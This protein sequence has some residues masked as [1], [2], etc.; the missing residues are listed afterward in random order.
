MQNSS[1]LNVKGVLTLVK[2]ILIAG[3]IVTNVVL[4]FPASKQRK[5]RSEL[6]LNKIVHLFKITGRDVTNLVSVVY[7]TSCRWQDSLK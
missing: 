7:I 6:Q 4:S 1:N 5:S 2:E 3:N